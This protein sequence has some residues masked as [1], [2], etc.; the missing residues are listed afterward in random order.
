VSAARMSAA[1]R[2]ERKDRARYTH[3]RNVEV[4]MDVL[5]WK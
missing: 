4:G 2:A 5:I 3:R 1:A